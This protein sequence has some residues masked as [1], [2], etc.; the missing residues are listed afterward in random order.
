MSYSDFKT[1]DQA[2]STLDLTVEDIPRLFSEIKPIAPSERLK[3]TLDEALD[4]A[5]SI[6]TEK[7]RSELIITPILL[8]YGALLTTKLATFLATHLT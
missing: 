5:S 6:S 7:A 8:E 1:I 3:E 2:V 4:L